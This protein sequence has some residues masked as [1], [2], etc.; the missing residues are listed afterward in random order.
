M[1][2]ASTRCGWIVAAALA[3]ISGHALSSAASTEIPKE[4]LAALDAPTWAER[5]A[6]V[7]RLIETRGLTSADIEQRVSAGGLAPEQQIRLR[8]VARRL[9]ESRAFAALGVQFNGFG[10][11]GVFIGET[12]DGFDAARQL[13]PGDYVQT[14]DGEVVPTQ[15]DF[16]WLIL[17]R[18]PGDVIELRVL[19]DREV[20]T[21]RVT[22]GAFADLPN[23]LRPTQTDLS[24]AF[25][26][27]WNARVTPPGLDA[28]GRAMSI[29]DW[30]AVESSNP[31]DASWPMTRD[32]A[33]SR[34]AIGG[35]SRSSAAARIGFDD[36]TGAEFQR[37]PSLTRMNEVQALANRMRSLTIERALV[38]ERAVNF[39]RHADMAHD[40]ERK[41]QLL[42]LRNGALAD[43]V[44]IDQEL[45]ELRGALEMIR[46]G[47]R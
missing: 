20:M 2:N 31:V 32:L 46:E 27:R 14:V 5:D 28:I 30:A 6:A 7:R 10:P 19:R 29:E 42:E 17:S 37:N 12:I 41:R 33:S 47:L 44:R 4:L 13:L 16:R 26:K 1:C 15:D 8:Q 35:Q 25:S 22:L 21:L 18:D 11:Q 36:L 40:P 43:I 3:G 23:A 9:F 24:Y 38:D 45:V 34:V 39:G